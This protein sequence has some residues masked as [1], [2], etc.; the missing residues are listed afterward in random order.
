M[1]DVRSI[2]A[3]MNSAC[4]IGSD[5]HIKR[6]SR[7]LASFYTRFETTKKTGIVHGKGWVLVHVLCQLERGGGE[8]NY[9]ALNE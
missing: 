9:C 8:M 7:F 6:I 2:R 1:Y 5:T 4:G 3:P